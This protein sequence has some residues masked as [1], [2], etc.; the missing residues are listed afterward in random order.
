MILLIRLLVDS[1]FNATDSIIRMLT[2]NK[3][4]WD[5][6]WYELSLCN[7]SGEYQYYKIK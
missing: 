7:K 6:L 1:I 2:N 4:N 5:K 3:F